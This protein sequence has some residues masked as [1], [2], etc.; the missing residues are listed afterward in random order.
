MQNATALSVDRLTSIDA[1]RGLIMILMALDHTRDFVHSGAMSFSPDDL[2]R[3]TAI[4]F[5]TRWV[6][7]ICAPTFMFLAGVS[8]FLRFERDGSIRRLSRFLWTR[9]LWLLAIELTVMRLAMNFSL[10]M[11][12][13]LLLLVLTALGLSMIVLAG[14]VHLPG[15]VLLPVSLAV[16]L[17]HNTLD[18]IQPS[19]FG[20]YAGLWNLLHQPGVIMLSGLVIVVGYPLIPWFAVMAAGFGAGPAMLMEPARRQR[21]LRYTG[22]VLV[23][24]FVLIRAVNVYGDP[25]PWSRQPSSVMTV[26]SFL[27]TTKYPPSLQFLLMTLGPALLLL[28]WFDRVKPRW[29]EPLVVIGHVPLFFYVVHFWAIHLVVAGMSWLRYGRA[30]LT[31]LFHPLPSMGGPPALFPSGFGYPLWV[32]YLVWIGV[33][34]AMYPLCRWYAAVKR[35]RRAWWL[36]YL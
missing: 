16:I 32:A 5:L 24:L 25:A 11:A 36:S 18:G 22:P 33:V 34:V 12:N 7:H 29:Q 6:T 30:S 1:L 28:S 13:P 17:L 26:L 23:G 3:T 21:L 35:T 8:A 15:R 14:L 20:A 9:G 10:S 4:L 19:R 2:N 31:F 27:R